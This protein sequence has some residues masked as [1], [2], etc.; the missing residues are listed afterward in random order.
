VRKSYPPLI[1]QFLSS[2]R[3]FTLI[4]EVVEVRLRSLKPAGPVGRKGSAKGESPT[5]PPVMEMA[6]AVI[7]QKGDDTSIITPNLDLAS[8]QP[9]AIS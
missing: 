5:A 1:H 8:L 4:V 6:R 2:S 3:K 7:G 9:G